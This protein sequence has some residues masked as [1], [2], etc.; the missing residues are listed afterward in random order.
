VIHD[1]DP[2]GRQGSRADLHS[3]GPGVTVSGPLAIPAIRR[4]P[5]SDVVEL[6]ALSVAVEAKRLR[7]VTLRVV[8]ERDG[9]FDTGDI[10]ELIG[11]AA[12]Q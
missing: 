4:S 2:L 11:R 10:D 5:L 6:E 8:G 1:A 3:A 12:D 7:W 9:R